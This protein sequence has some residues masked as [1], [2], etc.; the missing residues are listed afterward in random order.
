MFNLI[1]SDLY[2]LRKSIT[3]KVFFIIT[4]FSAI[5]MSLMAYLIPR[6]K[7]DAS[8]TG[9]GFLFS[10]MNMISILGALIAAI[11]ICGD[12]ENK[13]IHDAI[14]GG[15]SRFNVILSKV[16]VCFCGLTL[17][18]LPY[19]ITTIIV[20]SSGTKFGMD[21]VALGFLNIITSESGSPFTANEISKLF[22]TTLT[23]ITVYLSQISLCIPLALLFKKPI[24]IVAIYYCFTILTAQVMA[25]KDSMPGL[26]RIA[27]FTP[28]G[29]NYSLVNFSTSGSDLI[30]A[31]SASIFFITLMVLISYTVFKKAEIK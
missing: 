24:F 15:N 17:I 28:F 3:I 18:L 12:F 29:G 16:A 20:L 5:A 4:A 21:S 11:C 6:G 9:I 19:I 27:S 10:D 25:L 22:F 23:L 26:Y 30:K 8:L 14:A 13:T 7:L 31:F 1:W 2:K